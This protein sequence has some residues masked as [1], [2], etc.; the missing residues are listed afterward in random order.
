MRNCFLV[1]GFTG[2]GVGLMIVGHR[3]PLS[4]VGAAIAL[5]GFSAAVKL[6]RS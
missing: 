6:V 1:G 4:I 5:I 3:T 2:L